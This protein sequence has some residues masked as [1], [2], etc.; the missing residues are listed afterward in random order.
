MFVYYFIPYTFSNPYRFCKFQNNINIQ[1]LSHVYKNI[2]DHD[3]GNYLLQLRPSL[4]NHLYIILSS[5][6]A[7]CGLMLAFV[8]SQ[9]ISLSFWLVIEILELDSWLGHR[10]EDS[11][12]LCKNILQWQSWLLKMLKFF[13]KYCYRTSHFVKIVPVLI[14]F[15]W[16]L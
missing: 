9:H 2:S 15:N 10:K 16:T 4:M 7:C 11:N 3:L 13:L 14:C 12:L 6:V 1:N 8:G 5:L